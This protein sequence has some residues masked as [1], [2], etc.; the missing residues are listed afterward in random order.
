MALA[1]EPLTAD[2]YVAGFFCDD[3]DLD[4]FLKKN[5]YAYGL[6]DVSKTYVLVNDADPDK[7]VLAYLTVCAGSISKSIVEPELKIK[8]IGHLPFPSLPV[9]HL[10]KLATHREHQRQGHAKTM[11]AHAFAMAHS[12]SQDLGMLGV[13]LRATNPHAIKLYLGTGFK[14]VAEND[15]FIPMVSIRKNF[16]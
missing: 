6:K 7:E 14:H 5:A 1:I 11:M 10:A 15:Y 8:K 12:I 13:H 2:H 16:V 9:F 4:A 3:I